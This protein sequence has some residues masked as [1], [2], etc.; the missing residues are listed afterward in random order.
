MAPERPRELCAEWHE[1]QLV[2]TE[3]SKA[4]WS[5]GRTGHAVRYCR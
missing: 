5:V 1:Y 3:F 2:V 4:I